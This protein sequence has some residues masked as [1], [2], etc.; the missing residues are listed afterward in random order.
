MGKRNVDK[1]IIQHKNIHTMKKTICFLSILLIFASCNNANENK[2]NINSETSSSDVIIEETNDNV[3]TNCQLAYLDN[4]NELYFYNIEEKR[5]NKFVEEEDEILNFVL[6]DRG[7]ILYYT[8]ERNS[9]LWLKH[10]DMSKSKITPEWVINWQ[11]TK[12]NFMGGEDTPLLYYNREVIIQHDF[13]WDTYR[14]SKMTVY[15]VANKHISKSE[16]NWF[17]INKSTGVLSDNEVEQYFETIDEHL[18]YTNNNTKVGLTDKLDLE[19]VKRKWDEDYWSATEFYDYT[20]SPDKTK[21]LF[22]AL[23]WQGEVTLGPYCISNVDGSNQMVLEQTRTDLQVKPIWLK[24]NR[25]V[26]KGDENVLFVADNDENSIQQI[27]KNAMMVVA[28]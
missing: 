21:I 23:I 6:D 5:E 28:R 27:A 16:E 14:Y 12:D 3:Y 4:N 20:F 19:I 8:V 25:A 2:G 15:S 10:A 22:G 17:I 13:S 24:N 11:L 7:E 1:I 9:S 26:F 18:Y